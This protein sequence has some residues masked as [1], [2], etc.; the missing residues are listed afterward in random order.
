MSKE[1]N[2]VECTI[3][4]KIVGVDEAQIKAEKLVETINSAKS[5]A[6]ELAEM[7]KDMRVTVLVD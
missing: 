5:L 7:C 3:Q 6:G 4:P 2:A 1:E